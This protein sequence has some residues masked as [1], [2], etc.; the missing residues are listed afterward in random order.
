MTYPR[1]SFA[2][3]NAN[4]SGASVQMTENGQS[5]TT[6]LETVA[7][8]FGENTLV[9]RP[10]GLSDGADWQR[11][12]IDA[13]YHVTISNVVVGGA[14]RTFNYDVTVF[15]PLRLGDF[16]G[17]NLVNGGLNRMAIQRG[18]DV[19]EFATGRCGWGS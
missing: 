13:S 18:T 10:K 19:G 7:N 3:A 15:D 9:W 8:G 12:T 5:I 6:A 2:Y 16:N 11:P 14:A 17:D 4:F 1:W